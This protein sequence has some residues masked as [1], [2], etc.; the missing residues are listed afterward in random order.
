MLNQMQLDVDLG[1]ML[2]RVASIRSAMSGRKVSVPSAARH[3]MFLGCHAFLAKPEVLAFLEKH[4]PS[5]GQHV[6][7]LAVPTPGC[8]SD[9]HQA[10]PGQGDRRPLP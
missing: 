4:G 6:G 3:V 7:P 5:S 10:T 9:E 8:P 2:D 1:S